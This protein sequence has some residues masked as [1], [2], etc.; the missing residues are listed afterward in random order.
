M[1]RLCSFQMTLSSSLT[2][3][4]TV[5]SKCYSLSL[6]SFTEPRQ[7]HSSVQGAFYRFSLVCSDLK[8]KLLKTAVDE[9]F[10]LVTTFD[11]RSLCKGC[12]SIK[13]E[14]WGWKFLILEQALLIS[15]RNPIWYAPSL[16]FD[17]LQLGLTE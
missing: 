8:M 7:E 9:T 3:C 16:V 15:S 10:S 11:I 2:S 14:E 5:H 13:Q 1:K 12:L 6:S 17:K 4:S